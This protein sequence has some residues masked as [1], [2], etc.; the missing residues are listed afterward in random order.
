MPRCLQLIRSKREFN[1]IRLQW[2]YINS[3]VILS[4]RHRVTPQATTPVGMSS[5]MC[6]AYRSVTCE[7]PVNYLIRR[8][9]Y[10]NFS[11]FST[12]FP[13]QNVLSLIRCCFSQE[14]GSNRSYRILFLIWSRGPTSNHVNMYK[15]LHCYL[16][17]DTFYTTKNYK[18][19]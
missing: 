13:F 2:R 16:L 6:S 15:I 4:L 8:Y 1:F 9:T 19:F 7:D 18:Y 10:L 11:T 17:N 14:C 5:S 12:S 3:A